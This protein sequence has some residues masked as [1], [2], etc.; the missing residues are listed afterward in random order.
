MTDPAVPEQRHTVYRYHYCDSSHRSF[1]TLAKCIWGSQFREPGDSPWIAVVKGEMVMCASRED[2]FSLSD[3]VIELAWPSMPESYRYAAAP[4]A[5][6]PMPDY[7]P[8]PAQVV[9]YAAAP[10]RRSIPVVAWVV[11]GLLAF[12]VLCGLL[13]ALAA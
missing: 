4:P 1:R 9:H 12:I 10:P 5:P 3:R 11:M 6:A 13:G 8:V 2:A 7:R